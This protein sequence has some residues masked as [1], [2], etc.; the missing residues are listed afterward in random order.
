MNHL[1]E[2]YARSSASALPVGL[3]LSAIAE[4]A[5]SIDME[6]FEKVKALADSGYMPATFILAINYLDA[7]EPGGME[8]L[9]ELAD[10][11]FVPAMELVGSTFRYGRFG[12]D[13]DFDIARYYLLAASDEGS[14]YAN[15]ELAGLYLS[16]AGVDKDVRLALDYYKTSIAM[17]YGPA[18]CQIDSILAYETG[19]IDLDA[20]IDYLMAGAVE[21]EQDCQFDLGYVYDELVRDY[22]K[23]IYWYQQAAEANSSAALNNLGLLHQNGL[24]TD[25]NVDL[26]IDLF[27]RAYELGNVNGASNLGHV[28]YHGKGGAVDYQKAK[29]YYEIAAKE[30]DIAALNNLGLIYNNGHGVE[31]NRAKAIVYYTKAAAKDEPYAQY[32]LGLA[33]RDG[34]GV[35][36]SVETSIAYF[37]AS[38]KNGVNLALLE[39]GKVYK[40]L[41]TEE[42]KKKS[43]EV[44]KRCAEL[45]V[46]GCE[47]EFGQAA[48]EQTDSRNEGLRVLIEL[49]ESDSADAALRLAQIYDFGLYAVPVNYDKAEKYYLQAMSLGSGLAFANYGFW[50]EEGLKREKNLATAAKYYQEAANRYEDMGLNNLGTFYLNGIQVEKD[51][52]KGIELY[53]QAAALGNQ[54][55]LNNLGEIYRDGEHLQQDIDLAVEYFT[56]S[57]EK[58]F[59]D[60]LSNLAA[61]FYDGKHLSPDY[62]KA[63]AYLQR[64]KEFE[65]ALAH[66]Y[67][68]DIYYQHFNDEA[69]LDKAIVHFE[70][71][72][73]LGDGDAANYLGQMYWY[74]DRAEKDIAKSKYWLEIARNRGNAMHNSILAEMHWKGLETSVDEQKAIALIEEE[75]IARELNVPSYVAEHFHYGEA[76]EQDIARAENYYLQAADDNDVVALTSLGV[77]Y[78]DGELGRADYEKAYRYFLRGAELGHPFSMFHLSY[79]LQNGQGI[80]KDPV[81][82]FNWMKE[83]A[84]S[85]RDPDFK[86]QLAVMYLHGIG[87]EVDIDRG[88]E[89]LQS[90]ID[91]GNEAAMYEVGAFRLA[92]AQTEAHRQS[93]IALL[94][95]AANKGEKDAEALLKSLE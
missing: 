48:L 61:L 92:N 4:N 33:Y 26:A 70:A 93:A 72:A 77:I 14:A 34:N 6:A 83:A 25:V 37:E 87:T 49:A 39:L 94:K 74:A 22:E 44:F 76:V 85:D 17:G 36:K 29:Y 75:A 80:D 38:H 81:A 40:G 1:I 32:N 79:A 50:H 89:S 3:D 73:S 27:L 56:K 11:K 59:P 31:K 41:G 90:F 23:A 51:I 5:N 35:A 8:L 82:A 16:G 63:I 18:Q 19:F 71:S 15:S 42:G 58:G 60:A 68:G 64:L 10:L 54:Y 52:D 12:S 20:A 55:A 47:W 62:D 45:G 84:K 53:L 30:G 78:R 21:G 46:P 7:R 43:A 28:Y 91:Q 24:G 88:L 66:Y 69:S 67:L 95:K 9:V 2:N 13:I 65:P 86:I 57:A